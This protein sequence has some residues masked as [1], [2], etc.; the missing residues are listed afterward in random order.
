LIYYLYGSN[1]PPQEN[2]KYQESKKMADLYTRTTFSEYCSQVEVVQNGWRGLT[3][4]Q[5]KQLFETLGDRAKSLALYKCVTMAQVAGVPEE[6]NIVKFEFK[7]FVHEKTAYPVIRQKEGQ[8]VIQIDNYPVDL[9]AVR[10]ILNIMPEIQTVSTGAETYEVP[11]FV[12]TLQ[13]EPSKENSFKPKESFALKVAAT[14]K[15][16]ESSNNEDLVALFRMDAGAPVTMSLVEEFKASSGYTLA[17]DLQP[18]LY[19]FSGYKIVEQS[20]VEN[21]K[22]SKWKVVLV[23]CVDGNVINIALNSELGKFFS[24][25]LNEVAYKKNF[26][27]FGCCTLFISQ[28]EEVKKGNQM[29]HPVHGRVFMSEVPSIL[30]TR[31]SAENAA[32]RSAE[33]LVI[34]GAPMVQ[35]VEPS[36]TVSIPSQAVLEP[37][38]KTTKTNK[39]KSSVSNIKPLS[40]DDAPDFGGLLD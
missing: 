11:S 38:E 13:E 2:K 29:T 40:D 12:F 25:A 6:T 31:F 4:A 32:I 7:D 1:E 14:R 3:I 15:A 37:S 17:R 20:K 5:C 10:D 26:E 16:D 18:G 33:A 35:Q 9:M 36:L 8:Y 28:V 30:I 21:G 27:K 22:T 24:G 19:P 34:T 23:E 39:N